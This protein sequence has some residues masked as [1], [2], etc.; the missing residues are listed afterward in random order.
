MNFFKKIL[1]K[2]EKPV[3]DYDEFWIWFQDNEKVFFNVVSRQGDI[4]KE[5]FDKLS[6]KLN[7]LKDGFFYLTGMCDANTAELI[8]TADGK[9]KNIVFVE[10]LVK[11]SPKIAG[12]K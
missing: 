11:S 1:A 6:P 3:T 7:E 5:F 2:K 9:I 12:W 8:L 10:E 4:E